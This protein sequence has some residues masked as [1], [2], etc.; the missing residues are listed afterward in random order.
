MKQFSL[1]IYYIKPKIWIFLIYGRSEYVTY[2][3]V[4]LTINQSAVKATWLHVLTALGCSAVSLQ[5]NWSQPQGTVN[6]HPT[7]THDGLSSSVCSPAWYLERSWRLRE[8]EGEAKSKVQ[9]KGEKEVG[10][11]E[12]E[13]VVVWV[14]DKWPRWWNDHHAVQE[15]ATSGSA[16]FR[17]VAI[18]PPQSSPAAP[19]S[20]TQ[21][22]YEQVEQEVGG[23]ELWVRWEVEGEG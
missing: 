15:V 6:D 2:I 11:E 4:T 23:Q 17:S 22:Q 20:L 16:H 3:N 14:L 18:I 8:N 7:A 1:E 13:A 10:D 12:E 5:A 21:N 9:K 19:N